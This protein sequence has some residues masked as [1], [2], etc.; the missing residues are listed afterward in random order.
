MRRG[1][2]P[3]RQQAQADVAAGRVLV[4]GALADRPSRLVGAHEP[5]ELVGDPP[6]YVGRGGDKLEAALATF[7]VDVA[8]RRA[9]D[10]GA[11]TG[12]FTDCLLQAGARL[13]VAVDVG[14]GQLHPR[15]RSDARVVVRERMNLRGL[16]LTDVGGEPFDVVTADLSFISLRT[17]AAALVGVTA[18]GGHVMLLVKP[19]F[20]AGRI[21]ASRGRGVIRDPRVW[22]RAIAGVS[23]ALADAGAAMMGLMVSPLLGAEG[24]V[25]FFLHGR[26]GAQPAL[27]D[28]RAAIAEGV[29]RQ[30]RGHAPGQR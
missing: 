4:A 26:R 10:A 30:A 22:E 12:G 19:Q 1:L 3:S 29:E 25:E 20:E 2:A 5:L 28:V 6:R 8:G 17:V 14:H 18:A 7:A 15:L 24:N 9:L 23:A 13:V 21:D 27:L 16:V 11:S